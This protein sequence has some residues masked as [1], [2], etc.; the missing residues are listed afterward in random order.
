VAL[1]F[2]ACYPRGP[3]RDHLRELAECLPSGVS[4]WIGGAGL[5]WL[6]RL[7]ASVLATHLIKKAGF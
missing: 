7:P 3:V 6:R 1:S 5:W 4:V 2:S